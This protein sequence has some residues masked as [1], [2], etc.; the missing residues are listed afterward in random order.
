LGKGFPRGAFND[1]ALEINSHKSHPIFD[2][3]KARAPPV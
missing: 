2:E 3:N 1:V